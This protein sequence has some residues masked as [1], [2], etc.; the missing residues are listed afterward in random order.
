[1]CVFTL[2]DDRPADQSNN[3]RTNES[4]NKLSKQETNQPTI[5]P[6]SYVSIHPTNQT[7]SSVP[8]LR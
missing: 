2:R 6:T 4:A 1:M 8:R 3:Q 7:N 5:P